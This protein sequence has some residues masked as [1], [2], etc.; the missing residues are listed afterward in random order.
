MDIIELMMTTTMNAS[1]ATRAT[2]NLLNHSSRRPTWKKIKNAQRL[3][4]VTEEEKNRKKRQRDRQLARSK[5]Q[6]KGSSQIN[7]HVTTD[8]AD[9]A[10]GSPISWE[11]KP[12]WRFNNNARAQLNPKQLD[13]V[14][15][16][17]EERFGPYF[18]EEEKKSGYK[19][20]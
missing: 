17:Y 14:F 7:S 16:L 9:D 2:R 6:G 19:A 5:R 13:K 12:W 18:S 20:Y 4:G 11:E 10:Y 1:F 8:I 15:G 3:A